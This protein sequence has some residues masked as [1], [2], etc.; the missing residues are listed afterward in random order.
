MARRRR[1]RPRGN[2]DRPRSNEEIRSS[3]VRV[4]HPQE[5]E[6]EHEVV[7]I[8]RAREIAESYN[9]DLVEVA[10]NAKP[11]VCKVLD[12]GKYMYKKKKKEKEAKKKQHTV[13]VKELRFRPN[14]DDHDL[15]FKT[16]HARGFLEDGDKVKATVQFRGRD[17]LYTDRGK[18]L[19]LDLAEELS[20]I[21][22]IESKPNMEGRRMFMMLAPS[23]KGN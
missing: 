10:P 18:E 4:I 6:K 23:G 16:R 8:D 12:F 11:P 17:M 15:N 22:E 5:A 20:D 1:R 14:T 13:Q 21:S 3:K 2:D 7:P 19:L 9:L